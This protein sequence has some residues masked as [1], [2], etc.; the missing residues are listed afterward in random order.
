MSQSPQVEMFSRIRTEFEAVAD[1]DRAPDMQRYMKSEMPF[2]GIQTQQRRKICRAIFKEFKPI[3]FETWVACATHIWNESEFREE[4]YAAIELVLWKPCF[5]HHTLAALPMLGHLITTGAWWDYCDN[6]TGPLG[7]V[8]RAHPDEMRA[9]MLEWAHDEDMWKR[10]SAILCQLRFKEELDFEFLQECI[11]PSIE[12]KEFFLRKGIGWALR[13]YAWT[14]PLIVKE[15]V[16]RNAD[17]LSGL[18]KREALKN[19][20]KLI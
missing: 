9:L 18:S 19:M 14:H 13:D 7:N 17:R 1:A 8:L 10:R 15:Y 4:R 11:E 20:G 3:S 16:K 6:L 5:E 2:Y 12:S